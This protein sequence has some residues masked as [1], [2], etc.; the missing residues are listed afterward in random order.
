MSELVGTPED[1]FSRVAAHIMSLLLSSIPLFFLSFSFFHSLFCYTIPHFIVGEQSCAVVEHQI[2]NREVLG[3]TSHMLCSGHINS[4][5]EKQ[6][7]VL[8]MT[9]KLFLGH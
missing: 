1:R 3:S 8:D 4:P 6:S 5:Q 2:P 7:S 9:E